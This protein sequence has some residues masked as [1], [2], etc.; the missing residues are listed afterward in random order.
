MA[1]GGKNEIRRM[2]KGKEKR[3]KITLKKV[4][5]LKNASF[6]LKGVGKKLSK[7]TIYIPGFLKYLFDFSSHYPDPNSGFGSA[8]QLKSIFRS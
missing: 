8:T 4:K 2:K 7:C 6:G 3:R 1:N 5:G